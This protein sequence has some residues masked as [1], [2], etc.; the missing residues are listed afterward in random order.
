MPFVYTI[1]L[2]SMS[3]RFEINE[4]K[5]Q[6]EYLCSDIVDSVKTIY[7]LFKMPWLNKCRN[8]DIY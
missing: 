8:K 1:E 4:A 7:D 5:Q 2:S 3:I 6:T